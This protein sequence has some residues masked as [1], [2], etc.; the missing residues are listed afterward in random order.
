[1]LLQLF[2]SE[3]CA[4]VQKLLQYDHNPWFLFK[5]HGQCCE[6]QRSGPPPRHPVQEKT[7]K[8]VQKVIKI[9]SHQAYTKASSPKKCK[10]CWNSTS[11]SLVFIRLRFLQLFQYSIYPLYQA[12]NIRQAGYQKRQG[13]RP[14]QI[15]GTSLKQIHTNPKQ[16]IG[17]TLKLYTLHFTL[18]SK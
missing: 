16:K 11:G 7:V 4:A 10:H 18:W 9:A 14:G 15:S 2:W 6:F 17:Y 12:H 5:N 3:S 13:I 8:T 1:M